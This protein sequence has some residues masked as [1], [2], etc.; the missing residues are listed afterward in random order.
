MNRSVPACTLTATALLSLLG[1]VASA[2]P[3]PK[4][5]QLRSAVEKMGGQ[6]QWIGEKRTV[7]VVIHGVTYEVPVGKAELVLEGS[8]YPMDQT[9]IIRADNRTYV[10]QRL[11]DTL[12]QTHKLLRLT[13]Q[14]GAKSRPLI[15]AE[16][17][18]ADGNLFSPNPDLN[19]YV[20]INGSAEGYL[21]VNN[22]MRPGGMSILRIK[23]GANGFYSVIDSRAVDF[24]PVGGT[25]NNCAG[26]ATP[27]GTV[28]SGE[29]YPATTQ[30]EVTKAGLPGKPEDYGWMVEVDPKT[31]AVKK[32]HAMG[33][34]SHEGATVLPDRKT[35]YMGDDFRGGAVFKFVADQEGDLS[36]GQLYAYKLETNSWIAVPRDREVLNDA[37]KWALANGATPFDRPEEI[38]YNPVDGMIYMAETGDTRQAGERQYGRVWRLNPKTNEMTIF[39][40]G[41]PEKDFYQPDNIAVDKQGNLWVHEDKYEQFLA[42]AVGQ[43]RNALWKVTLDGKMTRF[44]EVPLGA[45]VTGG[46]F[47]PDGETLFVNIQHPAAPNKATVLQVKS[48]NR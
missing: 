31:G 46:F 23:K 42:P 38:E 1:P 37:R 29:E 41:G 3:E 22:E 48:F 9:T 27:W 16:T 5:V 35:V 7:Q 11:I 33:R 40:Q 13:I 17:K 14:P 43:S 26:Q 8:K 20:P 19:V 6:V 30:E 39:L 25:W 36:A 18:M 2:D 21:A 45:E 34:F 15:T 24:G 47:T 10:S 12:K 32:H 4:L 44:M 28:L